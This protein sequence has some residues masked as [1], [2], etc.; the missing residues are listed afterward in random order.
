MYRK[1][2]I[3]QSTKNIVHEVEQI[4]NQ[5]E[6][7]TSIDYMKERVKW[8]DLI[9]P[10]KFSLTFNSSKTLEEQLE[11]S[12]DLTKQEKENLYSGNYV[13]T[14]IPSDKVY[15][16]VLYPIMKD[17]NL[18][19]VISASYNLHI[20][21]KWIETFRWTW[22]FVWLLIFC[23]VGAIAQKLYK[24]ITNPLKAVERA[25]LNVS[26]GNYDTLIEKDANSL[27]EFRSFF[28]AFNQ[29]STALKQNDEEKRNFLA[30]ISHEL[31]TPLSYVKGYSHVILDEVVTDPADI[32]KY[33]ALIEREA[34]SLQNIVNDLLDL[35][36]LE[37]KT[38]KVNLQPLVIAQCI[39]EF[40]GKCE[41]ALEQ[42]NIQLRKNLNYDIII[43]GD[44]VRLEQIV[45]NVLEN[46][47]R[48]SSEGG[49]ID[50][51]LATNDEGCKI[52]IL[53]YG[54][55]MSQ[56]D[57]TKVKD[58]FYRVNKARTR[59]DGG[60]GIGLSIVDQLVEL[61]GGKWT[62]ESELDIGTKVTIQLPTIQ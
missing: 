60:A 45:R 32:K 9:S 11:E 2:Y 1:F 27:A 20:V 15:I 56:E 35:T 38:F 42:K 34:T 36:Q 30:D 55:G 33:V 13:I 37:A 5:F 17:E 44:E 52:V 7:E 39:E 28:K 12:E 10:L 53:D 54:I 4:V 59:C 61:H 21:N 58:R 8:L 25:A 40:V 6:D 51:Y 47:I 41:L 16:S 3:E 24:S 31:R 46:A 48:Y 19:G 22:L 18:E 23:I 49:A 57:L 43:N 62:I 29:M 50:I 14:K 26:V